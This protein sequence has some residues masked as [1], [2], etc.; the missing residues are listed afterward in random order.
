MVISYEKENN[1]I[2]D[3]NDGGDV[4]NFNLFVIIGRKI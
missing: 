4:N 2:S 1:V 3:G